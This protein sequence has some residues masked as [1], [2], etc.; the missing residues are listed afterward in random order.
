MRIYGETD[1][2]LKMEENDYGERIYQIVPL[3]KEKWKGTV[4]PMRY[5]TSEYYDVE[6]TGE[7]SGSEKAGFY[8]KINKKD[9]DVL[10]SH[11]PEEY[12]FPDKLYQGFWEKA[13]AWGVLRSKTDGK[14]YAG[15]VDREKT[16]PEEWEMIACIETCP[17]EWS[18][19]LRVTELWVHENY[20]GQGMAHE[21]MAVAR[22]QARL[23]RRRALILETQSCNAGAISFYLQEGFTLIGFDSCCYNNRDL[24][25]KEVRLELGILLNHP[26]KLKREEVEIRPEREED[27][28]A[29]EEMTMHAFWNKHHRGCNEH[30]LV[31]KMRKADCYLPQFS[32]IA[33]KDGRVI[34]CIM[35][36]R[37]WLMKGKDKK[38]ILTFGP[39][40]VEPEW[41]GTGVGEMLLKETIEL[42]RTAGEAGV[43]IFGEPDYYPRRGFVTCDKLGI[44]TADGGNS[45]AFLGY[46][47]IPGE[48][49]AFGGSFCEPEVF[50]DLPPEETE[51]L[52]KK[53]P[54]MQ[55]QFFPGQWD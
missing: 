47:L 35:Y 11:Y 33:V 30:L 4:I 50:E 43:V 54:P 10:V 46:E 15:A 31:H 32:R 29:T 52:T 55:K 27:Y 45:E 48:L 20:R 49:K 44:T 28:D 9:F 21:L 34:G 18:N 37:A 36:S 17:E 7:E 19:R 40:C 41:H 38:E 5:T 22:E 1:Y 51:K 25:R 16:G 39:L 24:E 3:P 26:P 8:V 14:L 2:M 6:V 53:F 42:A 23:E 13:Y 12:D